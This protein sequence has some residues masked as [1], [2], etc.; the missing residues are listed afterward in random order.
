MSEAIALSSPSGGMSARARK[1]ADE[2]LRVEL[3]GKHGL[4]RPGLPPQP[5][6]REYLLRKAA[7]LRALAGRGVKPMAYRKEAERLEREASTLKTGN[8]ILVT[9]GPVTALWFE[10]GK[11]MVKQEFDDLESAEAATDAWADE[12]ALRG[13]KVR[14]EISGR[15]K[16]ISKIRYLGLPNP[17]ALLVPVS[18]KSPGWGPTFDITSWTREAIKEAGNIRHGFVYEPVKGQVFIE[19]PEHVRTSYAQED[20][21]EV[22]ESVEG[23]ENP[24]LCS[25]PTVR[26]LDSGNVLIEGENCTA[27]IRPL[28]KGAQLRLTSWTS[29]DPSNK[30]TRHAQSF[31]SVEEA[32]SVAIAEVANADQFYREE[33]VA[34]TGNPW[35]FS[36]S[37]PECTTKPSG[38]NLASALKLARKAGDEMGDTGLFDQWLCASGLHT[39]GG[40][41]KGKLE[42]EFRKGV[43]QGGV[44]EPG[45]GNQ[46]AAR[47]KG[48]GIHRTGDEYYTD[49]DPET[50]FEDVKLAKAFIGEWKKRGNPRGGQRWGAAVRETGNYIVAYVG[51]DEGAEDAAKKLRSVGYQVHVHPIR[52]GSGARSGWKTEWWREYQ[53]GGKL[54]VRPNPACNGHR[55]TAVITPQRESDGPSYRVEP[56][57]GPEG[58]IF[59]EGAFPSRAQ[60]ERTVL[61]AVREAVRR[62]P[63][64][65]QVEFSSNGDGAHNPAGPRKLVASIVKGRFSVPSRSGERRHD[66]EVRYSVDPIVSPVGYIPVQTPEYGFRSQVEAERAALV[67]VKN[68]TKRLKGEIQIEFRLEDLT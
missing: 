1:R 42:A 40:Y 5:S 58:M 36:K 35:P 26:R 41:L 59:V 14:A 20:L 11:G 50:L 62:L 65:Y 27:E 45:N 47:Y 53:S 68:Q 18:E 28:G 33:G 2:R 16:L 3:F 15:G 13:R 51:T 7:E 10:R 30:H 12:A 9:G 19:F 22:R 32:M 39:R 21:E 67:A 48:V 60:A 31:D 8:P 63:G 46:E 29:H 43:E 4:E 44:K 38:M 6:E 49:L 52:E 56:I 54:R 64:T 34:R 55:L 25:N 66:E 37:T 61:E 57:A 24:G 17:G 23:S